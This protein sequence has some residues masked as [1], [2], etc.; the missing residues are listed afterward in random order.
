MLDLFGSFS[1]FRN[2]TSILYFSPIVASFYLYLE[3]NFLF[4][5]IL[6]LIV[7]LVFKA[8]HEAWKLVIKSDKNKL[9]N[10]WSEF[11]SLKIANSKKGKSF[12]A[13]VATLTILT[14]FWLIIFIVNVVH[15]GFFLNDDIAKLIFILMLS[16]SFYVFCNIFIAK[17]IVPKDVIKK[18]K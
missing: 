13:K 17:S 12:L 4:L 11:K 15:L 2:W 8:Y 18:S 5:L 7:V 3:E 1:N 10:L 6:T 9:S 16:V 14:L